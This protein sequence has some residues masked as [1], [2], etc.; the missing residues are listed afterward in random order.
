MRRIGTLLLG[1]A[2]PLPALAQAP[3]V[4]ASLPDTAAPVR[5]EQIL[6]R[7]AEHWLAQNELDRA[8]SAMER[9]LAAAPHDAA[10]LA[11]A[12]RVATA[13]N[14]RAAATSFYTQLQAANPT[15]EQQRAATQALQQGTLDRAALEEARKLAREGRADDAASRYRA[16]FNGDTPPDAYALEFYQTMAATQAY[17]DQGLQGLSRLADRPGAAAADR[18]ARA[19]ALTYAPATR[20]TGINLLAALVD[21]PG[22]SAAAQAA[23][24]EAL[25][26][27][28]DDPQVSPLIDAYRRRFPNDAALRAAP[29]MPLA[30]APVRADP[31]EGARRDGFSRLDAGKLDDAAN[32]F[33]TALALN[34]N[35]A[36]ALGGLGIL[37]LRQSRPEEALPLLQRAVTADAAHAA[38]WQ[39]PL[40]GAQ[41]GTDLARAETAR[42]RGDNAAAEAA[43]RQA[44]NRDVTDHADALTALGQ[45]LQR[46]GNLAEAQEMFRAALAERPNFTA[47]RDGLAQA[48]RG[49][50][51]PAP[52]NAS[53]AAPGR[54]TTANA[55]QPR[56]LLRQAAA[57]ST[58]PMVSL[59]LLRNAVADTPDDPW[60]RL[61]L[62][63]ALK[64]L[65]RGGEGRAQLEDLAA[66]HPGAE[67]NYAAA[68]LAQED[69]RISDAEAFLGRIAPAARTPD[70]ARLAT[71]LRTS[72]DI[73]AAAV[74]A[75]GAAEARLP[76]LQIAARPDPSGGT[77]AEVVAAFARASDREGAEEAARTGL[78]ANRGMAAGGRLDIASALLAAGADDT[79]SGMAGAIAANGTLTPEQQ[80]A[81]ASLRAG[82]AIRAADRLN[83]AGDQTGAFEKLRPAL[84]TLPDDPAVQLALA[85]L[86]QSAHRPADAQRLAD[87]VLARDPTNI[88]ARVGAVDAALAANNL[89]RAHALADQARTL[90]PGDSR[91]LLLQARVARADGQ[92]NQA[93]NLLQAAASQRRVELASNGTLDAALAASGPATLDR[94][95]NPFAAPGGMPAPA[96]AVGVDPVS[97]D[98]ATAMAE[99]DKGLTPDFSLGAGLRSR[100]GS[101]GLDRLTEFT[102]PL[103]ASM[104]DPVLGGRL[105]LTVAPTMLD[106]GHIGTEA[107]MLHRLGTNAA[108]GVARAPASGTDSGVGLGLS[109]Q[110]GDLA[111]VEI[112][113]TPVGFL[114]QNV[115][116]ALEVAPHLGPATLRLSAEYRP[117]TDSLL[118][119]GGMRDPNT[120]AI[121]GGV[122]R[123]GGHAQV[124]FPIGAGYGYAGGGYATLTGRETET[125]SRIEGG[126]GFAY[127]IIKDASHELRSGLD[128]VYFSFANNQSGFGFG[129]GGYFSPQSYVAVNVPLDYRATIGDV[130]Y[131]V[132]GTAGYAMFSANA[133]PLFPT[134]AAWQ[135][136]AA[137]AA[138]TDTSYSATNAAQRRSGL[139]GGVRVDVDYALSANWTLGAA[140]R[141]DHA[142]NW[143]E[144]N[145]SVRLHGWF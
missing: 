56:D 68:L 51:A 103:Q 84:A 13:R 1:L 53:V 121:W 127:P 24:R 89:P 140:L 72:R 18:L 122:M 5:P 67:V 145:I 135:A 134:N 73:A 108:F 75:G 87:A 74:G 138:L 20:S 32:Q 63:R 45:L 101:T 124:E 47:A 92:D 66:R 27:Y 16:V 105:G 99:T 129:Q 112:G 133:S 116:G 85:R 132:G 123:A 48:A 100:S 17:R 11:M 139:V 143:Q 15:P 25:T 117:V 96:S 14:D 37:R 61:D 50:R 90:L 10:T 64:R 107:S 102:A 94:L 54:A 77:T 43:L 57:G 118:S 31:G 115:T 40:A 88:E 142:A 106:A 83:E 69:G 34:P 38:Q 21:E 71:Q 91:V 144:S 131:R 60:L 55:G 98:I 3:L 29:A 78:A 137:K 33:Q 59:A 80:R 39:K 79:V 12:V 28:G 22:V 26:Y 93:R 23:W 114:V 70:M 35:D 95:A 111:R 81:L 97:R 30:S 104:P 130:T 128:L 8:A 110:K 136:A 49:D 9:A 6:V 42:K 86:Y 36:D 126:A 82:L 62:A 141:F 65:G 119:Y 4:T 76:L 109:Y 41:F 44:I 2:A 46:E 113:S 58:D 52:A 7:Q 120:G 125:N 19:Q